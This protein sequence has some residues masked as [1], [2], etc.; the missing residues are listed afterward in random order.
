MVGN[1]RLGAF[2]NLDG[3][4]IKVHGG[5]DP[6]GAFDG[7]ET[8]EPACQFPGRGSGR[9]GCPDRIEDILEA[10]D[11]EAEAIVL[12]GKPQIIAWDAS[13]KLGGVCTADCELSG[14]DSELPA[15]RHVGSRLG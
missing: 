3:A 6:F 5:T 14:P 8:A 7:S 1:R 4:K 11:R 2:C 9:S 12:D 15:F 10:F 13:R